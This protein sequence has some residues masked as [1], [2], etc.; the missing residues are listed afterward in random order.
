VGYKVDSSLNTL[1]DPA[2]FVVTWRNNITDIYCSVLFT[3]A[4]LCIS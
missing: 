2:F 3:K 1:E 4:V